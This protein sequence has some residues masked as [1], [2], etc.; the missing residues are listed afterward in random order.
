MGP[1]RK[2]RLISDEEKRIIA[3]HEA[4][5]AVV[6]PPSRKPTRCRRSPS[7]GVDRPVA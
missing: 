7:S 6:E 3:Y 4:G 2:S 1:E 5:H